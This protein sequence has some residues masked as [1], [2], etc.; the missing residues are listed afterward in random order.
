MTLIDVR[1]FDEPDHETTLARIGDG[2]GEVI[3]SP[4]PKQCAT[5]GWRSKASPVPGSED[6]RFENSYAPLL[7]ALLP[8]NSG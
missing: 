2:P 8:A 1:V 5:P 6:E 3:H 4:V 7:S